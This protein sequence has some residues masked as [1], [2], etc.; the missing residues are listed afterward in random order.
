MVPMTYMNNVAIEVHLRE[1]KLIKTGR[2][3]DKQ[4]SYILLSYVVKSYK[5]VKVITKVSF[6]MN[7]EI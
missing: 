3:K 1:L 5:E 7:K 6:V 4:N 2:Q